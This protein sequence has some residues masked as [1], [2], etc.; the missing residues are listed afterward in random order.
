MADGLD[1]NALSVHLAP[2]SVARAV[3]HDGALHDIAPGP[4]P[5]WRAELIKGGTSN[6]P[7]PLGD[8]STGCCADR[9]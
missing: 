5:V 8:G 1:L 6:L 3:V 2:I 7:Y 9:R 4:A